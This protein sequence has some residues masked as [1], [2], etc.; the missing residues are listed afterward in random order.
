MRIPITPPAGLVSDET[1][2]A[3]PGLWSDGDNVRF[4]RGQAQVIGGWS[5]ANTGA[6]TGVCRSVLPWT[7]I[8]GD[9]L[10]AFG[11]HSKLQVL[12]GGQLYDITPS[13]LAAGNIDSAGG[14]G[15]GVGGYGSGDYGGGLT[16]EWW[17][18]TWSLSNWGEALIAN[19]RGQTIYYWDADTANDATAI[20]GAPTLVSYAMVTPERQVLAFGCNE[21]LSDVFNPMC[22]RGSDIG[23][24]EDWTVTPANNAFEHILEGSGRIVGAAMLGA[25]VA[26]WT[27]TSCYLGQF[28]GSGGQTY[29][30]DLVAENCGL[31]GPNAVTVSNGVA[32]WLTPDLTPYGWQLG[33]PPAP[34]K[35][36][37]RNEFVQNFEAG[38]AEK[39]VACSNSMFGEV[40]F[41]YPDSRDGIENSRYVA[42]STQDGAWFRGILGRTAATDAGPTPNPL[43]VDY[44]GNVYWHESGNSA[45]GGNIS[46][47]IQSSAQYLDE[48]QR[49]VLIRGIWPDFENQ[50]GTVSLNV[51]YRA[52]P[53]AT[54]RTKGP[55]ALAVMAEKRD[56]LADG[57]I[58]SVRFSGSSAPAF[59]RFGKPTFD[60][61]PTGGK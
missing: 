39:A 44:S 58:A 37:I 22:I 24:Y 13:G 18:R 8:S 56:F 20:T 54:D 43:W 48:A 36:P 21:E 3:S 60:V 15:Y 49:R 50:Q 7:D 53:Q 26:V 35:F 19:P 12:K 17:A 30:F 52:Y 16:T 61:V 5:S 29:R 9:T 31:L 45:N 38:Q 46:W 59:V 47:Y 40:W 51:S 57:R 25:Y 33:S 34:L 4:W 27:D 28:I 10:I 42:V 2:F 1:T 32:Y 11:T 55:Y 23:D 14:P 41:F 6:L